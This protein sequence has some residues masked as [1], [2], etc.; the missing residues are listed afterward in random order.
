MSGVD[1]RDKPAIPVGMPGV[2][3]LDNDRDKP[4]IP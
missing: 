1:D 3:G 2:P 4:A